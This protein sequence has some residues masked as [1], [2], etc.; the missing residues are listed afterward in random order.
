[1]SESLLAST[2]LSAISG[3]SGLTAWTNS[4]NIASSPRG[5]IEVTGFSGTAAFVMFMFPS[6]NIHITY[7]SSSSN[8][9]EVQFSC[10]VLPLANIGSENR[11]VWPLSVSVSYSSNLYSRITSAG[12]IYYQC[13][14]MNNSYHIYLQNSAFSVIVFTI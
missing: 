13:S 12:K 2:N 14:Y 11:V 10:N 7:G 4:Y 3:T 8:N 1:M 6:G 9:R 5:E